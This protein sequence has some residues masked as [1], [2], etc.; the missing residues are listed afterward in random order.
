[1]YKTLNTVFHLVLI[2]YL[3]TPKYFV[4]TL[5]IDPFIKTH[6]QNTVTITFTFFLPKTTFGH[7]RSI[8]KTH[9]LKP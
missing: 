9:I 1:M 3:K 7:Q 4:D 8:F 6:N 5:Y 2:L